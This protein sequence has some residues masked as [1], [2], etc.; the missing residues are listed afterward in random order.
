MIVKVTQISNGAVKSS[1]EINLP[2]D[3]EYIKEIHQCFQSNFSN[4]QINFYWKNNFLL[5]VCPND[6]I[7]IRKTKYKPFI[8]KFK[9]AV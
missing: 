1:I 9:V 2:D 6:L 3:L 4:C 7:R 5:G 8:H